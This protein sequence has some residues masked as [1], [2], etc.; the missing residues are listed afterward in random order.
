MKYYVVMKR[1]RKDKRKKNKKKN[2]IKNRKIQRRRKSNQK[3]NRDSKNVGVTS[4]D[5]EAVDALQLSSERCVRA[6]TIDI[7]IIIK[8]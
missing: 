4:L 7:I 6:L 2:K 1:R 8:H 3:R 5:R